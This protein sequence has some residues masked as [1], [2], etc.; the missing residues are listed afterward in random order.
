VVAAIFLFVLEISLPLGLTLAAIS[1]VGWVVVPS[2]RMLRFLLRDARLRDVRGRAIGVA[3][4]VAGG[5][6]V[7]VGLLPLPF[8]TVVEGVVWIPDESLARA[9]T[10]GFIER[11]V[12]QP[13]QRIARGD[14]LVECTDPALRAEVDA[15]AARLRAL[16]A[17]YHQSFLED[18]VRAELVDDERKHVAKRLAHARRRLADLSVRGGVDGVLVIEH[19][20]DLP[21]R[22][23]R[24]GQ[25]LA[26]VVQDGPAKVRAVVSQDDVELLR[27]RPGPA[28]VRLSER[29]GDV[30]AARIL[31]IVP[32]ATQELPSSA[33]GS[34]GGGEVAIDPRDERGVRAMQKL[35]TVELELGPDVSA[36]HLGSRV[37]V[38]FDHGHKPLALQW[39]RSLRQLFLSRLDV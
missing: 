11:V 37:Y 16:D 19:P 34:A 9:Q 32:A 12:A 8:R 28:H 29:P 3:A 24:K 27:E 35:F 4:G 22:W 13:G 25:V 23:A 30:H 38:R 6:V 20:E 33:L 26:Q 36:H 18:P 2:V 31:R 10:S 7:L 1:L 5:I 17:R 21:G 14:V 39:Y 15:L